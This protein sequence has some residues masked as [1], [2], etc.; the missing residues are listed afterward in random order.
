MKK[1]KGK[2][3]KVIKLIADEGKLLIRERELGDK[4]VIGLTE[5][6]LGKNEKPTDYIEIPIIETQEEVE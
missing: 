4:S 2:E 3:D 5:V 6:W 1:E